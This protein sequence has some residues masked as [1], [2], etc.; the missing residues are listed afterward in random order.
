MLTLNHS[1]YTILTIVLQ[2]QQQVFNVIIYYSYD[3]SSIHQYRISVKHRTIQES[4][5]MKVKY[6]GKYLVKQ[7]IIYILYFTVIP[8]ILYRIIN[9]KYFESCIPDNIGIGHFEFIINNDH[10][11]SIKRIIFKLS[12]IKLINFIKNN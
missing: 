6:L 5:I 2:V 7:S 8:I 9:E 10:I 1:K 12:F 3:T 11:D 4:D